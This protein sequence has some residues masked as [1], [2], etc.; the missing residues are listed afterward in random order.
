MFYISHLLA[1]C[2]QCGPFILTVSMLEGGN[3]DLFI[4]CVGLA[5]HMV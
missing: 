2:N 5:K 3:S 1:A 4:K